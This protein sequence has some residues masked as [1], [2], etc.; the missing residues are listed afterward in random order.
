[1]VRYMPLAAVGHL[2]RAR[3]RDVDARR[4]DVRL[5]RAG[6]G[7]AGRC[8]RSRRGCRCLSTAPTVSAAAAAPGEPMVS[9]PSL[10]AA[11]TNSVPYCADSASTACDIGSL[12]SVAIG[13]AEAHVDDLGA[14]LGRPLHAGEDPGVLAGAGVVEHLAD[15]RVGARGRHPCSAAGR[16]TGADDGGRDVGAVPVD[17]G[18]ALAGDEA[19]RVADLAGQVGVVRRR[20]RCRA[21]RR[22][23]RCR[24]TRPPR[25]RAR[26]SAA[27]S[28]RGS[29]APGRRA[30]ASAMPSAERRRRVGQA[31]V[32]SDGVPERADV[33][34]R[35]RGPRR[36]PTD[37]RRT[38]VLPSGALGVARRGSRRGV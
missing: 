30:T 27:R 37:S 28:R 2:L 20:R 33:R 10:P 18:D 29:P 17:V 9:G 21:R 4:D 12:P 14:R 3:G 16:G 6:A 15:H 8:W 1:M 24:R 31:G 22:S 7:A 38:R 23:R 5:D 25:P 35:A 13:V 32:G 26:R 11:M 36:G 34:L 19:L